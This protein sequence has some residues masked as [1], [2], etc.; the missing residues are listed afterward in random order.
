MDPEVCKA[1]EALKAATDSASLDR[2]RSEEVYKDLIEAVKKAKVIQPK[3]VIK[4]TKSDHKSAC[5]KI[6]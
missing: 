3:A 1:L 5:S 6:P 4:A 2:Q